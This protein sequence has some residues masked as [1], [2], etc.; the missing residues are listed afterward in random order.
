[1]AWLE[2]WFDG[3]LS[4]SPLDERLWYST[5]TVAV[6]HVIYLMSWNYFRHFSLLFRINLSSALLLS[7]AIT[8]H[9]D[10]DDDNTCVWYN[11]MKYLNNLHIVWYSRVV[12]CWFY[13]SYC[14][15]SVYIPPIYICRHI[16]LILYIFMLL[17]LL[18][19]LSVILCVI[20]LGYA[21]SN[22]I[23]NI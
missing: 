23:N 22:N 20:T 5:D 2:R 16:L 14:W 18:S 11:N 15:L 13:Y 7:D 21:I 1:M 8:H 17:L 19:W 4:Y 12:C 6:V 9:N 10:Y 3:R